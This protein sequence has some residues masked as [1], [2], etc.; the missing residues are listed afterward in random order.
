MF[1][2]LDET[3]MGVVIDAMDEQKVKTGEVVITEG[4]NGDELYVLEDGSLDCFK[5][6]VR[7]VTNKFNV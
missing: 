6:Q 3:D 1:S 5:N 2:A 4:E 7:F